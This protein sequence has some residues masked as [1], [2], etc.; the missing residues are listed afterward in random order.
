[1][2]ANTPAYAG[3]KSWVPLDQPISTGNAMPVM[4]DVLYETRRKHIL[5]ALNV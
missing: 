3:C 1:V 2:V 5:A 4:D